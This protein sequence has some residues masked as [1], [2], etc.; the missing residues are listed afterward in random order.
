MIP[1]SL[2]SLAKRVLPNAACTRRQAGAA[3]KNQNMC[4]MQYKIQQIANGYDSSAQGY[5]HYFR[6]ENTEGVFAAGLGVSPRASTGIDVIVQS[7]WVEADNGTH[8][9]EKFRQW[10]YSG[11]PNTVLQATDAPQGADKSDE[12]PGVSA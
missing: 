12:H 9:I 11:A 10:L 7:R 8:A 6:A 4:Y 1:P 3:L 5:G 2:L